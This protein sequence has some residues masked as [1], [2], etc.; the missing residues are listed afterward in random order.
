MH[1]ACKFTKQIHSSPTWNNLCLFRVVPKLGWGWQEC[2]V[3][4]HY[5][6]PWTWKWGLVGVAK[7]IIKTSYSPWFLSAGRSE[8]YLFGQTQKE[9]SV[10]E[11]FISPPTV[12]GSMA[13]RKTHWITGMIPR[14]SPFQ[15]LQTPESTLR[16]EAAVGKSQPFYWRLKVPLR[17]IQIHPQTAFLGHKGTPAFRRLFFAKVTWEEVSSSSRSSTR[18]K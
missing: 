3:K 1:F 5:W 14:S 16:V 8:T 6:R 17:F 11:P 9:G 18:M 12:G 15:K 2:C 7:R 4:F 10:S 13:V